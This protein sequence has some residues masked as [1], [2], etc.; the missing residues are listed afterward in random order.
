MPM[1]GYKDGQEFMLTTISPETVVPQDH[2]IRRIKALVD[3]QLASLNSV[4]EKMY[5]SEGRPSIPPERLVKATLLMALYSVRSERQLCEQIA[6]NLLFRFFLDMNLVEEP[7]SATVF[8]KN[9]DRFLEYD[10]GGE[11]FKRVVD[12]ARAEGLVSEEHFSVDGTLIEAWASMKSFRPKGK[13]Q[14]NR[15]VGGVSGNDSVNFRDA[16][17]GNQTHQS[18]TDPQARLLR[19]GRGKEAKLCYAL[20]T[21][22]ENRHGLIVA[23][24]FSQSVG[25]TESK[26]AVALIRH[27][28][29]RGFKPASVGADKGYHTPT[30]VGG[31]RRLNTKP[32]AVPITGR[33]VVGLDERTMRHENFLLSQRKRK[34][35]EQGYGWLKTVAGFRKTRYRGVEKNQLIA[36]FLASAYN[37]LRMARLVAPQF[38]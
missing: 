26:E 24:R 20:H 19:K 32:H 38:A 7:F 15:P 13:D 28:K 23:N 21:A 25:T 4:F 8:T 36:D 35:I 14:G 34:L 1:R 17:H 33:K 2:P 6:Y 30:F 10:L 9:R 5:S 12:K 27:L 31:L 3:E 18:V 29:R 22:T 16:K 11:F 37:L